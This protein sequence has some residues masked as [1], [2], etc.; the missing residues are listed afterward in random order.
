[1]CSILSFSGPKSTATK[2]ATAAVSAIT[3]EIFDDHATPITEKDKENILMQQQ[4]TQLQTQTVAESLPPTEIATATPLTTT[5]QMSRESTEKTVA[6]K[7]TVT[8]NLQKKDEASTKKGPNTVEILS[9]ELIDLNNKSNTNAITEILQTK[10][11]SPKKT[12]TRFTPLVIK[13]T[14]ENLHYFNKI[15]LIFLHFSHLLPIVN[16]LIIAAAPL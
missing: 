13:E 5:P 9:N 15:K 11:V 16:L 6:E 3:E 12:S 4:E 2:T 7:N 8:D 10:E 1:M 14:E